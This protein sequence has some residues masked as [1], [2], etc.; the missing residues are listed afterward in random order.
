MTTLTAVLG[1]VD[2]LTEPPGESIDYRALA[3]C[4]AGGL[5]VSAVLTL[6]VVPLVYTLLDDLSRAARPV[7]LGMAQARSARRAR[8]GDFSSGADGAAAPVESCA[9]SSV[10]PPCQP[11]HVLDPGSK[12][13]RRPR[14]RADRGGRVAL[15]RRSQT[16]Q[17]GAR[18]LAR[19]ASRGAHV[20]APGVF[21]IPI[22]RRWR[23]ARTS[24]RCCARLVLRGGVT[25]DHWVAHGAVSGLAGLA[26]DR[27]PLALGI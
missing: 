10:H 27:V 25:H 6:W 15:P 5:T 12:Q 19:A 3:T 17:Q 20:P 14:P 23:S 2:G 4:I 8:T 11:G 7:P 24:T 13:R 9:R 18:E 21:E 16:L 1:L 22:A 26:R